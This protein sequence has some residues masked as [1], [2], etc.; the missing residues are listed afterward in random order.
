MSYFK[1]DMKKEKRRVHLLSQSVKS[2]KRRKRKRNLARKRLK[3]VVKD[4]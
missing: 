2:L 1:E 4:I 3:K